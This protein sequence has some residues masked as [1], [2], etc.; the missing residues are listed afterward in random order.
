MKKKNNTWKVGLMIALGFILFLAAIFVLGRQQNLFGSTFTLNTVF[1]SVSGL[2]VG[3]NVRFNGIDVGTVSNITLLTDTNVVV[4]MLIEK[5]KQQFIRKNSKCTIGSEGLMGDKI[6][7]ISTG[8]KDYTVV[9][10][11]DFIGSHEPVDIDEIFGSLKNT[12]EN[13]EII[14]SEMAVMMYKI[15]NGN[16]PLN[17]LLNDSSLALDISATLDNLKSSSEGLNQ[18]MEA[19]KNSFLL[20]GYFKKQKKAEE[21]KRKKEEKKKEEEL[22]KNDSKK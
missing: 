12:A 18:N 8:T 20:R 7:S 5:N 11:D 14:S 13:A 19:A 17:R 6:I 16:G 4:T 21:E 3:N 1:P 15:N 10:E 9:K 22:E 2:K